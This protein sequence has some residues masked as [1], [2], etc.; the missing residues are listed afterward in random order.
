LVLFFKKEPFFLSALT[1]L[2]CVTAALDMAVRV[3]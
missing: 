1:A 3:G 2:T